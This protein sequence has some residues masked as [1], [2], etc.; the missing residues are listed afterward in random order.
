MAQTIDT[1]T[2]QNLKEFCN[3]GSIAIQAS[4]TFPSISNPYPS[5]ITVSGLTGAVS[6]VVVKL[7]NLNHTNPDDID[8][9]LAAPWASTPNIVLMSDVGD[10]SPISSVNITLDDAATGSLPDS[11]GF[12]SGTFKPTNLSGDA[13]P[14]HI[15]AG[16][17]TIRQHDPRWRIHRD[18]PERRLAPVRDRRYRR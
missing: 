8:I 17:V 12:A 13:V 1:G 11:G 15:L 3:P 9:L 18:R 2:T 5:H 4:G 7:N 16:P 6:K 14:K 10:D